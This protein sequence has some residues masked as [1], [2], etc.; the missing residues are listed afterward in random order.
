MSTYDYS[1]KFEALTGG[2]YHESKIGNEIKILEQSDVCFYG[3]DAKL[4]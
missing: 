2:T 3:G 1:A 4:E